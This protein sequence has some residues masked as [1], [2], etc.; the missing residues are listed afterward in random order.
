MTNEH[1]DPHRVN[2]LALT[3]ARRRARRRQKASVDKPMFTFFVQSR[4]KRSTAAY[5][6]ALLL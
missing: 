6:V 1:R 4:L 2:S 3:A 5:P